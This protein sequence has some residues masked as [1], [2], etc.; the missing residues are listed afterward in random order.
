VLFNFI[1]AV[2]VKNLL[3]NLLTK[4]LNNKFGIIQQL[5]IFVE[6]LIN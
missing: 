2:F 3:F 4:K 5:F 6:L 1:K